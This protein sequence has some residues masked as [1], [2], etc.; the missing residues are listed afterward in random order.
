MNLPDPWEQFAARSSLGDIRMIRVDAVHRWDLYWGM[1]GTHHVLIVRL[2]PGTTVPDHLPRFKGF[3]L[4]EDVDG[5]GH[6]VLL[7]ELLDQKALQ[8]FT[9]LCFDIVEG[10][11]AAQTKDRMVRDVVARTWLWHRFLQ[12]G[13]PPVLTQEAQRG[14]IGELEV[15][16]TIVVPS[17][18]SELGLQGWTGPFGTSRDFQYGTTGL[19]VKAWNPVSR[20]AV[21]ISSEFQLDPLGLDSLF[22]AVVYVAPGDA[23]EGNTLPEHVNSVRALL[24][25]DDVVLAAFDLVLAAAGYDPTTDYSLWRWSVGNVRIFSVSEGFPC[26]RTGD[27][28][29]GV[30]RV[31]YEIALANCEPFESESGTLKQVLGGA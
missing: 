17:V 1:I 11:R 16:R 31:S 24:E 26:V 29:A 27:L 21:T 28:R 9:A 25:G 8:A 14:L 20:H 13:T 7:L 23:R 18:G 3:Q 2:P 15:F 4:R 10:T 22:L 12:F 5:T 6:L 30:S 19:E